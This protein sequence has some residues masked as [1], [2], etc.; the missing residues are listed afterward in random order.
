MEHHQQVVEFAVQ[1]TAYGDLLGD[2]RRRLIEIRHTL[3]ASGGLTQNAGHIFRMQPVVFLLAKKLDQR[4]DVLLLQRKRE[5]G[6][7][8]GALRIGDAL[9]DG[10][11]GFVGE[12]RIEPVC[13]DYF[14]FEQIWISIESTINL[15]PLQIKHFLLGFQSDYA[16]SILF[17]ST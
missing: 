6:T 13:E 12:F 14:V 11:V 7:A 1:I 17:E 10:L 15:F 16:W 9:A 3:Q 4:V 8:I 2:G 5:M